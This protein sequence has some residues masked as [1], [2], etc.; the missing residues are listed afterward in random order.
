M[1]YSHYLRKT[2]SIEPDGARIPIQ[3]NGGHISRQRAAD[4]SRIAGG[5]IKPK[6]VVLITE[7]QSEVPSQRTMHSRSR[8]HILERGSGSR[9]RASQTRLQGAAIRVANVRS[10]APQTSQWTRNRKA[11][12]VADRSRKISGSTRVIAIEVDSNRGAGKP[13]PQCPT[14]ARCNPVTRSPE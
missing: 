10:H 11:R 5:T 13:V 9:E 4:S 3:T 8:V 2:K 14:N 1:S 7:K 12:H 6:I